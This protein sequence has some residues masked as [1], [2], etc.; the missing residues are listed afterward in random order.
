MKDTF[1]TDF[2]G[3]DFAYAWHILY[4]FG[5]FVPDGEEL[6]SR[7]VLRCLDGVVL[8]DERVQL[9]DFGMAVEDVNRKLTRYVFWYGRDVCI[10]HLFG[11]S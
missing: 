6:V 10:N 3:P 4:P 11:H 1:E 7:R 5:D 8:D 9:D 2:A